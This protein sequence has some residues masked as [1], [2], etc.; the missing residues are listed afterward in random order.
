ML[1]PAG[2]LKIVITTDFKETKARLYDG[3]QLLNEAIARCSPEDTF[4]LEFG[5]KLAVERV[6]KPS[7]KFKLGDVVIGNQLAN[8]KYL[9]TTEYW[10]GK[11]VDIGDE[12]MCVEGKYGQFWVDPDVFD[13]YTGQKFYSGTVVCIDSHIDEFTIG[14]IY[15]F[16][17]GYTKLYGNVENVKRVLNFDHLHE[18]Y[19]A[20]F[21]EIVEEG[22]CK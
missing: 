20:K 9:I 6:M 17:D 3:K 4:D 15:K 19:D 12:R 16:T 2:E 10:T 1:K 13:K 22:E 21:I 18:L 14:R 5:A 7:F 8:F 11:V